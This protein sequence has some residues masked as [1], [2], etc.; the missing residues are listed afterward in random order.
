LIVARH[1]AATRALQDTLRT[2][3]E[4]ARMKHQQ[5]LGRRAISCR[6]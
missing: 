1:D 5:T 2:L 6:L 4:S 3:D